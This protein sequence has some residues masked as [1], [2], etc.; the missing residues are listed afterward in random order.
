MKRII[1]AGLADGRGYFGALSR[2]GIS[3]ESAGLADYNLTTVSDSD[4]VTQTLAPSKQTAIG[5]SPTE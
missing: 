3:E 1:E 5:P 4:K 2:L